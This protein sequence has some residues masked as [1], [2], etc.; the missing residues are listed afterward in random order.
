MAFEAVPAETMAWTRNVLGSRVTRLRTEGAVLTVVHGREGDV[1]PAHGYTEGSITYV[2][3]GRVEIDGTVFAPG[4]AGPLHVEVDLLAVRL[5]TGGEHRAQIAV[6]P[7]DGGGG[8]VEPRDLQEVFD[9]AAQARD[10]PAHQRAHLVAGQELGGADESGDGGAQFVRDVG[11]EVSLDL[12]AVLQASAMRSSAV[13]SS[14]TSS[15][16]G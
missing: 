11:G 1:V 6:L 8:R 15:R 4:D 5:E 9:Q 13:V 10:L 2:V 12:E 16:P 7:V 14:A 3:A